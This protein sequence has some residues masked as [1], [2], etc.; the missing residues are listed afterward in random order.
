MSN[1]QTEMK[2]VETGKPAGEGRFKRDG[3]DATTRFG[4]VVPHADVGPECELSA[5][6]MPTVSIHAG[7]LYFSA[8]RADGEMDEKLPHAP[9]ASFAEPP[10]ID[11]VVESLAASPLDAIGLAFTSSAYKH[12][13]DGEHRLLQR[14]AP[15]ARHMPMTTTCIA[16]AAAFK[17]TGAQRIALVNP[18]W[19]DAELDAAGARY[20]E[21]QGFTIAHHA[22]CGLPSGQKHITPEGLF[23]WVKTVVENSKADTVFVAGNGQ[24]AVGI[25]AAVE[26]ELGVTALTANQLILWHGLKLLKRNPPIHYYGRIFQAL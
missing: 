4:A 11:E 20:F 2:M 13:V 25:I 8:M 7:R 5:I 12:G 14:L 23:A 18:P 22:P 15:R 26:A 16:A 1:E 3:W 19:F 24:R 17:E 6:G 9:I 10:V 21:T